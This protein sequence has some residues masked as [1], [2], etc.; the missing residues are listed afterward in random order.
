VRIEQPIGLTIEFAGLA[1]TGNRRTIDSFEYL[2]QAPLYRVN[3]VA[4]PAEDWLALIEQWGRMTPPPEVSLTIRRGSLVLLSLKDVIALHFSVQMLDAFKAI[5]ALLAFGS[6]GAA[7]GRV[8]PVVTSA[9]DRYLPSSV[10]LGIPSNV[11]R[12]R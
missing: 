12:A 2:F 6:R 10:R 1:P 3:V 4:D 8:Q 5:R 9:L 11:G 7:A